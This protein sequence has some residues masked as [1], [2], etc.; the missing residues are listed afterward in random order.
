MPY[1]ID[2]ML[3]L[4]ATTTQDY[5]VFHILGDYSIELWKQQVGLIMAQHGLVS[6]IAHPDYLMPK[7]ARAAY[8]ALL[9]YLS[10]LRSEG[11]IWFPLPGGVDAW[12]RQRSQMKLVCQGGKWRIEGSGRE[13][14]SLAPP[15]PETKSHTP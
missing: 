13:R 14:G 7:R 8:V 4:P 2:R 15:W 6:F 5:T 11:T 10:Q 3:E 9:E 1:F 12:W